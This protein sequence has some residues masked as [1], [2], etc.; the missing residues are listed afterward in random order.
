MLGGSPGDLCGR[1]PT[2]SG[3]SPTLLYSSVGGGRPWRRR[4]CKVGGA[5]MKRT[6]RLLWSGLF[7]DPEWEAD[8]L[9]KGDQ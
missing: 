5:E 8:G 4:R 3:R 6:A 7:I 9:R 1:L 2:G